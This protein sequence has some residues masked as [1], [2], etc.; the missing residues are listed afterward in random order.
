MHNGLCDLK[1]NYIDMEAII[2][3]NRVVVSHVTAAEKV[4][5]VK[6]H[7]TKHSIN[8]TNKHHTD[9]DVIGGK[10][11]NLKLENNAF[12]KPVIINQA[13]INQ[14]DLFMNTF[15]SNFDFK[16]SDINGKTHVYESAFNQDFIFSF[17]HLH[18]ISVFS[19][20]HFKGHAEIFN[21]QYEKD[22]RLNQSKFDHQAMF[23]HSIYKGKADF[24][25]NIFN[26]NV[27]FDAV[28]FEKDLSFRGSTF[29]ENVSF[30]NTLLPS[31]VDF[32]NIMIKGPSISL[33]NAKPVIPGNKILINLYET[34]VSKINFNYTD[35]KLDFPDIAKHQE[36]VFIY[37]KLLE[38]YKRSG[39]ERS[40]KS[41]YR[42]FKQYELLANNRPLANTIQKYWWDYGL[43]KNRLFVWFFGIMSILSLLNCCFY[44]LLIT[45]YFN[46]YFLNQIEPDIACQLNPILNY[47]YNIPRAIF[48]TI[49]LVFASFLQPLVGEEK[50][51]KTDHFIIN[52]YVL[53]INC[54]GYVFI[55]FVLDIIMN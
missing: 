9:I 21:T 38:K 53:F 32:S 23:N 7:E 22:S 10:I 6:P 25:G 24:L 36:I 2:N 16:H 4:K 47:L 3:K 55:L 30:D 37:Q 43:E 8:H 50:L 46:I 5:N 51:F 33:E 17:N 29:L 31:K 48:L 11:S 14:I 27:S 44:N 34:D 15:Q 1:Q 19:S 52:S 20:I 54:L 49:F 13:V 39:M 45:K 42:E 28:R 40:Y 26:G 12:N 18:D 41:L 35:F